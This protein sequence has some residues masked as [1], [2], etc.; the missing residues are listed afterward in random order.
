VKQRVLTALGLI[1][2]VLAALFSSLSWPVFLLAAAFYFTG[3]REI[4]RMLNGSRYVWLGAAVWLVLFVLSFVGSLRIG[5]ADVALGAAILFC[6]GI[7]S[8]YL[9]ARRNGAEDAYAFA[10]S[11]W[12]AGPIA[13]LVALH[14]LHESASLWRFATPVLLAMAPLW[15]G[16]SAAIFAGKHFGRRKLWPSLSPKKTWEGALANLLACIAVSIP[17]G[18]WIGYAWP[19]GLACGF[20]AGICGQYG[21]LFESYV[22]RQA[23]L[24]DSGSILPGRGGVLDRIDSL[25]FTAPAVALILFLWPH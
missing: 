21:D 25:L 19:V 7:L 15:A 13:C 5:L 18:M 3:M 14:H 4:A 6:I 10:A 11:G 1:A 9:A 20:A 17:L 16:D 12:V 8:T 22:K 24:K 23:G 2:V